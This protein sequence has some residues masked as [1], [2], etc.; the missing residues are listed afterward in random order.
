MIGGLQP[1][2][3]DTHKPPRG[4]SAPSQPQKHKRGILKSSSSN[5]S[6]SRS[7]SASSGSLLITQRSIKWTKFY[8]QWNIILPSLRTSKLKFYLS[9]DF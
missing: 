9:P 4:R 5:S 2:I 8:L 6:S 7:R 3:V 1:S